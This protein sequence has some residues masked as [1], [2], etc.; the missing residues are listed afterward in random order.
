M[1]SSPEMYII[2]RNNNILILERNALKK[3]FAA[4]IIQNYTHFVSRILLI[5][6]RHSVK[7]AIEL[8]NPPQRQSAYSIF[9]GIF[10]NYMLKD[11]FMYKSYP[12]MIT[13]SIQRPV[14]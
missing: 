4:L 7:S 14:F 3:L 9:G 6:N 13:C 12:H 1:P 8:K 5:E 11:K 10:I 2:K